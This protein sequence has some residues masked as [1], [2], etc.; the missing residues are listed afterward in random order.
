MNKNTG[1][2][3]WMDSKTASIWRE[4][5]EKTHIPIADILRDISKCI[6]IILQ[7]GLPEDT[8]RVVFDSKAFLEKGIVVLYFGSIIC[9]VGQAELEEV[10]AKPSLTGKEVRFKD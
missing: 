6:K 2:S 1:T 8:N 9:G 10:L 3:I 4:L 5:S 7:D